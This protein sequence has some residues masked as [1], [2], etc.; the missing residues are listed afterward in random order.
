MKSQNKTERPTQAEQTNLRVWP[1]GTLA[2]AL[3]NSS[4]S[5]FKVRGPSVQTFENKQKSSGKK[6]KEIAS[7]E[8]VVQPQLTL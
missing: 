4:G 7:G 1:K 5:I 3:E 2:Q 6:G 8:K